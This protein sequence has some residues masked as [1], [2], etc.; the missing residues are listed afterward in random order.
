MDEASNRRRLTGYLKAAE[1]RPI[2][3]LCELN[4]IEPA[5]APARSATAPTR[6]GRSPCSETVVRSAIDSYGRIYFPAAG[7]SPHCS[8]SIPRGIKELAI[9]TPLTLQGVA[10]D[11]ES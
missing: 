2:Q 5:I 7:I 10:H 6:V 8:E 3:A 9:M 1:Q 4:E 11:Q